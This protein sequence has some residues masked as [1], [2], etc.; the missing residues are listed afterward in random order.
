ML[1]VFGYTIYG[2]LTNPYSYDEVKK[3]VDEE[4]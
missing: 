1:F 4:E 2:I 3:S